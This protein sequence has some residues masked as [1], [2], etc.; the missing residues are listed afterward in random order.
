MELYWIY[1]HL[2]IAF[3]I[4]AFI[5]NPIVIFLIFSE[6]SS[7]LGNYRYLLLYFAVFNLIYSVA[8]VL[9][10]LVRYSQLSLLFSCHH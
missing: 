2:P 1:Q 9:V 4:F 7:V 5:V 6:R 10:P 3:C 8:N